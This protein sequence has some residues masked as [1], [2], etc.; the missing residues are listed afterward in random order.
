M[1][2]KIQQFLERVYPEPNTGCWLWGGAYNDAGYGK[3]GSVSHN[4]FN[5]AHRYS[6][7]IFKGVF[8]IKLHVCHRCDNPAC[9]NPDHLFTGSAADNVND[10]NEKRRTASGIR[11]KR[12]KLNEDDVRFIRISNLSD[13]QLGKKFNMTDAAIW[14]VRN[15]KNWKHVN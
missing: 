15:R 10:R 2:A 4:G 8:D 1:E 5:L 13:I 9:V 7:Y 14:K 3:V 12:A 11:I 6:Y